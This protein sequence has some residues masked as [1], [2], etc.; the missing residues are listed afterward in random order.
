MVNRPLLVSVVLA[1]VLLSACAKNDTPSQTSN[2]RLKK[3]IHKTNDSA[4]YYTFNYDGEGKLKSIE[5]SNSQTH[6]WNAFFYYNSEGKLSKSTSMH[7]FGS[8]SNLLDQRTDSLVYD[9][10]IRRVIKFSQSSYNSGYGINSIYI[11]DTQNRLIVDSNYSIFT[12][13]VEAFEKFTYDVNDNM[14][15]IESFENQSGTFISKG[16]TK[17]SYNL[18]QN[19]YYGLG[20]AL[21][22]ILRSIDL[23]TLGKHVPKQITSRPGYSTDYSYEYNSSGQIIKMTETFNDPNDPT[24]DHSTA[25]FFY[26]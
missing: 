21:Y 20:F 23:T 15:Q 8:L 26:E 13:R 6:I 11:F 12:N 22:F 18:Q 2:Q 1:I 10:N 3:V 7:Y 17:V 14:I 24:P 9:N 25:D 19:P 16:A 4:G 5:L